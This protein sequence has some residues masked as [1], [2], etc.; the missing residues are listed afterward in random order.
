MANTIK[1]TVNTGAEATTQTVEIVKGQPTSV[2]AVKGARYELQ[3]TANKNTGPQQISTKRVGKNLQVSFDGAA[4]PD[5]IVDDYFTVNTP[6]DPSSSLYGKAEDGSLYEYVSEDATAKDGLSALKEGT[7]PVSQVLGG[8]PVTET[9]TLSG[10]P[11]VA[12]TVNPFLVAGGAAAAAVAA[13]PAKQD[14][15]VTA[16]ADL[17]ADQVAALSTTSFAALTTTDLTAL[18]TSAVHGITTSQIATLDADEIKAIGTDISGLGTA[19][20]AS[21]SA[22][23]VAAMATAQIAALTSSQIA[24]LS[25]SAFAALSTAGLAAISSSAAAGITTAQANTLDAAEIK[26]LGE[27]AANLGPA[28]IGGLSTTQIDALTTS[29]AAALDAADVAAMTTAQIAALTSSQIAA[30]STS[31]FAAL[32]TAGLAAISTSAAA[33]ITTSQVATLDAAEVQA[34]GTDAANLSPAAIGGLSTTQFGA[35][36]TAQVAALDA[37]D[38][39][40][41]TTAQIAALSSSQIAALSTAAF[42]ALS[43]AGLNA[44][45]S[46]AAAGISTAQIGTLDATEVQALGTDV[47]NLGTAAVAS[48][49]TSQV[50]ALSTSQL[51]ALDSADVAAL[52]DAAVSSL[53]SSQVAALST[54]G[55]SGLSTTDLNALSSTAV[56]GIT[57]AQIGTLDAAEVQALGTDVANLG[58]AAMG[59]LSTAQVGSLTTAQLNALDSADVAALNDAAVANLTSAQVAALSTDG[60]SGLSTTDLSALSSTAVAGITTAQISTLDTAEVQALGSD[61]ANLSTAAMASLSTAQ[62][63]ILT[64]DQ[65]AAL[66]A[67]DIGA[68]TTDQIAALTSSQIAALST[69]AF[70]ALSTAGL[71]A[72]SSSA[73]A[74]INPAQIGT[75]DTAEVQALGTDVSNLGT[76]AV[77]S[78]TTAQVAALSTAQLN[79]L[80]SAD[81]AALNDAAVTSL[82]SSQVAALSTNGFS[83]L[84]T[85]DLNAL[86]S[87]A[88]AGI[89]TAQIGTLDASEVQALGTDVANLGTAAMGTLSTAQVGSLTTA[90]LN[91]L[92]SADV[93]ALN[94][95]AVTSLTS[96][97]VAALSTNGF[98]GLSTTDLNALT[99]TAVAG[100][101]TAQIGTLDAAEVQALGADIANLSTAAMAALS[102]DQ[103]N[104][105]TT[106]QIGAL[107]AADIAALTTDQIAALTSNQIAALSTAAFAAFTTAGLAALS[108]SAVAGITAAQAGT[109]DASEVQA[110]GTDAANL[111]AST[112]GTLSATQVGAMTTDQIA[113]LDAADIAALTTTQIAALTSTQV[114]A[115]STTAFA[116]LGTSA[117]SALTSSAA[118]GI[119]TAQVGTLDA[120]EVVALGTDIS[121]MD[122]AA[123]AS[124]SSAQVAALTTAQVAALDSSDVNALTTIGFSG[125]TTAG[126]GALTSAAVAGITSAQ[127]ATLDSTEV[128]ALDADLSSLNSSAMSG[129]TDAQLFGLKNYQIPNFTKSNYDAL[130]I[131]GVVDG[132]MVSLMDNAGN[133]MSSAYINSKAELQN[134]SNNAQTIMNIAALG[135]SA[136]PTAADLTALTAALAVDGSGLRISG[137]TPENVADLW[138]KIRDTAN[139]GTGV[140]TVAKLQALIAAAND[141]PIITPGASVAYTENAAAV[142]LASALTVTDAD[143]TNLT[144]ATVTISNG[145]HTGDSLNF[146]DMN[147]I[148]GSYSTSTGVL[149]LTGSTTKANYEAALRTVTF[150]STND[151]PGAT[152]TI[153]WQANDGTGLSAAKTT[154]ITLTAVNDNPTAVGINLSSGEDTVYK[155]RIS[156]SLVGKVTDPD[157]G[158]SVAGIAVSWNQAIATQG[159]WEWS[160]DGTTAWTAFPADMTGSD[161]SF[162]KPNSALYLKSTAYLRFT[163]SAD[164]NGTVNP[165]LFRVADNTMATTVNNGDRVDV[166][167]YNGTGGAM[168]NGPTSYTLTVTATNDAP[169]LVDAVLTMTA[170]AQD[171]AAPSGAVGNLVSS[172]VAGM[173]DIDATVPAAVTTLKGIA[174]T[175]VNANGTLYYSTD[176]GTN[177]TAAASDISS[178]KSLLL[179]ADTDNRIYFKPNANYFGTAA[180]AVTFRA[181]D[182]TSGTEGTYVSTATTGGTSAFS[183]AT[184]TISEQV[185]RPVSMSTISADGQVTQREAVVVSGVADAGATV[186]G[187]INGNAFSTTADGSGNWSYTPGKVRYIMIRDSLQNLSQGTTNGFETDGVFN[188]S[189]LR[190]LDASGTNVAL[191]KTVTFSSVGWPATGSVVDGDTNTMVEALGSWS[192]TIGGE[193]WLQIDLGSEVSITSIE[194]LSR[195]NWATR[196][197]GATIYT[198]TTDMST[199]TRAQL[200]STATINSSVIN[201]LSG[202]GIQTYTFASP[203]SSVANGLN[204]GSNTVTVQEV[205]AGVTMNSSQ[206]ITMVA[207]PVFT[208][209]ATAST[210]ENVTTTTTVYD[211]TANA[212][213]GMTYT[214]RGTDAA[215]FDIN[216]TT[217][218]VTFKAS[219]NFEAPTDITVNN[220]YNFTVRATNSI[221]GYTD[222]I[223]AVT[224]TD[225]V[226][227]PV[228]IDVNRDGALTYGNVAIDMNG[229]GHLDATPWAGAG[230]GVLVWDKFAD[231]QVHNNSQYAFAQYKTTANADG[232]AATDLQGLAEAFD[233]N[234]DGVFDANDAKF[235]EFKVWQDVNQ[236]GVSDAGEVRSLADVG[237]TSINLTSDGVHRTPAAGVTE[238]GRTTAT[239]TDGSHVLVADAGFEYTSLAYSADAGHLNLLGAGINLD[240]ASATALHGPITE[241]NLNGTGANTLKINL[242]DVLT[243]T[244]L[245]LQGGSDDTVALFHAEG[246]SQAGTS[247]DAGVTYNVW[248]NTSSTEQLLIDQHMHVTTA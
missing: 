151:G 159:V 236:N 177:W 229:D 95:A 24:A 15:P 84:S 184:D 13:A 27:D 3:D 223:V 148:V 53:T 115:L 19:A 107:D 119:T 28:V 52:N 98:S 67:A 134:L 202:S 59:A 128:A 71:N 14:T 94:D 201:G 160:A 51:N 88:V 100:I 131:T 186:T 189:E 7:S 207:N 110:L 242:D 32:S 166:T 33:G 93:A 205:V 179:G 152:R 63:G 31:A 78:L 109:M 162:N 204:V 17:T 175:G 238:A 29:Q 61:I 62:V 22:A 154:T 127:V 231:G 117:L 76:A 147:G 198:S 140:N 124:L 45:S 246:W 149:T 222:Q 12:A 56:A 129:L 72:I 194:A 187:T 241:V 165:V 190:A 125:L 46:S 23:Q 216:A 172:Y 86:S 82:T 69:A 141:V 50:A 176:G 137:V 96:S 48:L 138:A 79:A 104:A 171:A 42:A 155:F 4:Q 233:T 199:L 130:G 41:M 21:L 122:T 244:T 103:L 99:S 230:D 44:I 8:A 180:D 10:L 90:Q 193:P 196:L 143:S 161:L 206:T 77:A 2:K 26:A 80:D 91:A 240:L 25:T 75:L 16:A 136:T 81:V 247:T 168:S 5:L 215:Q 185:V 203:N 200:D 181:W 74:G 234:H 1:V 144:G 113:A 208:S 145:L 120:T 47:S 49:T 68:L 58:T 178:T 66:D 39:A 235:A 40:A 92:D 18:T 195:N 227:A 150:S 173:S 54:N 213:T 118:A 114:A 55:F 64:T 237:I 135:S 97:Q 183:S 37:A 174:I 164:W 221:G 123:M 101:T 87:T 209:G 111:G 105:L 132:A 214:I 89:T 6:S 43:T 220:V 65:V 116:A 38:I 70:A 157:D 156:D 224:V 73:A 139:D 153:S 217:G 191:N 248:H 34:L 102:T 243:G 57:T 226:G 169:V 245:K 232:S 197:N 112:M 225:I 20:V 126:L 36:T 182:Q 35:L 146:V 30:L 219:P 163:P 188:M 211:A 212:D 218:A 121:N 106:A 228:V 133:N 192:T 11:A 83:G 85:T 167:T 158:A 142:T 210:A 239:A 108:N 9:F 170:V 60:F